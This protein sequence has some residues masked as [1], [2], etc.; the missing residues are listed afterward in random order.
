MSDKEPPNPFEEIQKQLNELF[1]GSNVKVSTSGF[2]NSDDFNTNAPQTDEPDTPVQDESEEVLEN[3]RS[4]NLKPKEIR[5]YLNRYVIRQDEAKKVISV[6]ICDHYNHVRQQISG[7]ADSSTEYSKQ[8]ILLLGPTGVGKTYLIKN[9]A[10]LIGVPF[11]KADATKFSET[12]Y[13]GNDVDDL[14][15]DLV[16]A[17]GGDVEL[18]Q[19]GIIFL[20][21]IDKIASEGSPGG[22]DVSGRGVQINL[23]KL[24]E[25]TEVNLFSPTDM[26]SQMQAVMEMQRG[27]K[28]RPKTISTRNILFIVS[29]AFDKLGE[30]I[31][32][33]MSQ[34]EM[35]F[36]ANVR[37][38][39]E[40]PSKYLQHAET[41]DFIKY[42]FEPEFIG[43]VPIRVA[44]E[45]LNTDDLASILTSSEG[46]ILNQYRDDFHGYGIDFNISKEAIRTLAAHASKERTGARG[47][48]TVLE[49]LFRNFKFELPSTA[50][51]SFD[52][53]VETIEAP[54]ATLQQLK[55]TNA[56]L[57]HDVWIAD[58]KRFATS[59]EKQHGYALE[60]KTLGED[61]L[62]AQAMEQDRTIQSL[63]EE[64]FKDF[65]HGL[66][67]INRNTGQTVFIIG[68]LAVQ[69][70]DKELSK[71][72]VRSIES[73]KEN[74]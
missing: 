14:V 42:G 2:S 52:V 12:G 46:S 31:Q 63:C 73:L 25:E 21:E 38:D 55:E 22:R 35:G 48:M 37:D 54:K 8:N 24:M 15:R 16:K 30:S 29:G 47:L 69:N 19:Y 9:I 58:I 57:Q 39:D 67:I 53:D 71:W 65:E 49:R 44:C 5:D 64:K 59:F 26:M 13:V 10:R 27:G 4:F 1:K 56:H 11:V 6:A 62:I 36:G 70:P 40:D 45:S 72:V 51:K 18:A 41:R 17:A 34:N 3:I 60:F 66:S 33:R 50:I 28:P 23:L 20:D 7:K 32:K 61:E 43:R 68:K 74:E